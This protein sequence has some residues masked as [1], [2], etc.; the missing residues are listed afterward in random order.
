MPQV[1]NLDEYRSNGSKVFAGRERGK[2]ARQRAGLDQIDQTDT[3]V[4]VRVPED[5]YSVNSS[6]FLGMFGPSIRRLGGEEFRRRFSFEGKDISRVIE[7]G[8]K[9]ALRSKAP[10]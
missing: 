9:E 4:L 10:L 3:T 1:I 6:F 5:I 8:I 2:L 7:D